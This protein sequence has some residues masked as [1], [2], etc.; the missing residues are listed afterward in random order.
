VGLNNVI[1]RGGT[2]PTQQR[3]V[4]LQGRVDIALANGPA[5]ALSI[6]TGLTV[7]LN[8]TP[9]FVV[10][11][12]AGYDGQGPINLIARIASNQTITVPASATSYIYIDISAA[13]SISFGTTTLQPVYRWVAPTAPVTDQHWFSLAES[14]MFR[15]SGTAW[16]N[17]NRVFIGECI[18]LAAAVASVIT[19]AYNNY[20]ES[21]WFAV[22]SSG[23]YVINHF[24]GVPLE[25]LAVQVYTRSVTGEVNWA[26]DADSPQGFVWDQ[27]TLLSHQSL[28]LQT[29]SNPVRN[30]GAY[31]ATGV[32]KI[33]VRRIW[34]V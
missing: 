25:Q 16:V 23:T 8:A 17:F 24:M 3:Q 10:A 4:V 11:F 32:M 26:S 20:F 34:E 15:W 14:K 1:Q 19:Y 2:Q 31:A 5:N 12:A 28:R 21:D 27:R 7:T 30:N 6:G 33:V 13:G 29:L 9:S 18:A 22:T